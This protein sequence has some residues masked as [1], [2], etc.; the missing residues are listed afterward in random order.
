M[1][2]AIARHRLHM[3][4]ALTAFLF[5][6]TRV[7]E[8]HGGPV[9]YSGEA[10]PYELEAYRL[11]G[12]SEEQRILTYSLYLRSGSSGEPIERA[13]LV[14]TARRD[15]ARLGP[16]QMS[17]LENH[18]EAQFLVEADSGWSVD[19]S[20]DGRLGRA[21]ISHVLQPPATAAET[22]APYVLPLLVSAL[23]VAARARGRGRKPAFAR[24]SQQAP[25]VQ[26]RGPSHFKRRRRQQL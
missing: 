12:Y 11:F 15:D 23:F 7:A 20:I 21:S 3:G 2:G 13:T 22:I 8:A 10:G 24:A 6:T 4:A 26:R 19:L 25:A 1:T 18:Y 5:L 17:S 14:A 16:T 9:V